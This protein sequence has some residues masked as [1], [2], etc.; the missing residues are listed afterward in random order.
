M[1]WSESS[2]VPALL[3]LLANSD[4]WFHLGML[5]FI[6]LKLVLTRWIYCYQGYSR[7]AFVLYAAAFL[8]TALSLYL[9]A[10]DL[11]WNL[12]VRI[13]TLITHLSWIATA[14]L[15]I[16]AFIVALR[17]WARRIGKHDW[18]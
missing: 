18:P 14:G 11:T 1:T 5:G 8:S 10:F 9:S 16:A 12:N 3:G 15:W 13:G 2:A 7:L 6:I 17:D 4:L